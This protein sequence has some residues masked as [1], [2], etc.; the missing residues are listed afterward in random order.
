LAEAMVTLQVPG[1][2]KTGPLCFHLEAT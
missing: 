1:S 2:S